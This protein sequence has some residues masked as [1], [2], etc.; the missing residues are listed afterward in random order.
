MGL[1]VLYYV[2]GCLQ[3]KHDYSGVWGFLCLDDIG[4]SVHLLDTLDSGNGITLH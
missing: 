3:S 4:V 1:K 2:Q